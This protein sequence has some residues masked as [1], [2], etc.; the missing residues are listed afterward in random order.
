MPQFWSQ[1]KFD[2]TLKEYLLRHESEIWPSIINKKAYFV[3]KGAR[4]E[5]PAIRK[6]IVTEQLSR[7]ITAHRQD[8]TTG[9]VPIGYVIA[10]KRASHAYS[11]SARFGR[12]ARRE[13]FGGRGPTYSA[14]WRGEITQK[15]KAMVGARQRSAGFMKVGWLSEQKL[16]GPYTGLPFYP[17]SDAPLRGQLKAKLTPAVHGNLTAIIENTARAEHEHGKFLPIGEPALQRALDSEERS[18]RERMEQAMRPAAE[19]F[20]RE[21]A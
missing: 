7:I 21:N 17:G 5:T 13:A 20:N 1:E 19:K 6:E 16:L 2:S 8:G 12:A 3:A 9:E 14:A 10:A 18:T 11:S 4:E 15:F